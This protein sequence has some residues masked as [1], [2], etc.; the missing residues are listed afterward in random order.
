MAD[1]FGVAVVITNQMTANPDSGMFA[2]DPLQ[3]IGGNIM[4]HA[5][6]TRYELLQIASF[7]SMRLIACIDF[8]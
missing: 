7:T 6:C 2:K 3:P 8:D 5:S 1:E 4:A